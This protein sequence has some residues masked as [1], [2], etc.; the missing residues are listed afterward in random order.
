MAWYWYF[1]AAWVG[2]YI[3]FLFVLKLSNRE[4]KDS[5]FKEKMDKIRAKVDPKMRVIE[6]LFLWMF[7]IAVIY[8]IYL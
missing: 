4:K 7:V 6:N 8:F 1:L 3:V 2:L 5:A